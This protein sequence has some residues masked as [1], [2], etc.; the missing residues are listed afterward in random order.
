MSLV[1]DPRQ[2]AMLSEMGIEVWLAEPSAAPATADAGPVAGVA[3][4]PPMAVSPASATRPARQPPV[5]AAQSTRSESPGAAVPLRPRPDGIEAMDWAALQ[6][7]VSTCQACQLCQGRKNTVFGTGDLQADWLIVGEAPGEEEDRQGEPF[8]GASGLLLDNMLRALQLDRAK[9]VYITNV[10]K[11]RPPANRNPQA[12]EV[13]EC[14]PWLQRQIELLRPRII[15]ALGR[16]AVQSLLQTD[17][18]IGKLR[19]QRHS[20]HGVPVIV[21]YHPDYLLR[22]LPEKARAWADLCLARQVLSEQATD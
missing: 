7:G 16:F 4:A 10:L 14:A 9:G 21:S 5:P 13:A 12:A 6:A 19:G 3:P 2:R 20:Y 15:L 18:P 1:L 11:C 17:E 8:V 22:N